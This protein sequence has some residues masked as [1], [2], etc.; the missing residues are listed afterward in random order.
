MHIPVM[1]L[2]YNFMFCFKFIEH[3][4][5][6][7]LVYSSWLGLCSVLYVVALVTLHFGV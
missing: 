6:L 1:F 3:V 2:Y 5:V 7:V 4:L